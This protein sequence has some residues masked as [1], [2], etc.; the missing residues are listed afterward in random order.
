MKFGDALYRLRKGDRVRRDGW[1]GKGM[2]V[3]YM[4]PK[5]IQQARN[6]YD[7]A[8]GEPVYDSITINEHFLIRNVDKTFS[9]WVPSVNDCFAEDWGTVYD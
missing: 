2:Y 3:C 1:N 5:V 7:M 6:L 9:T 8:D 4:P